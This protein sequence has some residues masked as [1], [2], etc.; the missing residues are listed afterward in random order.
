MRPLFKEP[1]VHFLLLGTILYFAFDLVGDTEAAEAKGEIVITKGEVQ[2]L[3]A[4]F[5]KTWR[6]PPSDEEKQGLLEDYIRQ[7]VYYREA[8]A[9]GLDR[10]DIVVRRRM[11][12]KLEF[13][14]EDVSDQIEP[15]DEELRAYLAEHPEVFRGQPTYSF[16]QVYLNPD[17]RENIEADALELL[18]RLTASSP[19]TDFSEMGD[20]LITA[21]SSYRDATELMVERALGKRFLSELDK[22]P[23]GEWSGPI[24]SGF[25]LHLVFLEGRTP[26]QVPDLAAARNQVVREWSEA[27]RQEMRS[28]IYAELRQRYVITVEKD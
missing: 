18:S 10:D 19:E 27:Q 22:L 2:R 1:L 14:T 25:G 3:E 4:L 8:L 6:R 7:E 26:G 20:R 15:T 17:R 5:E 13:L 21:E 24:S 16:I 12:Q 11:Q 9:A 28:A 23:E